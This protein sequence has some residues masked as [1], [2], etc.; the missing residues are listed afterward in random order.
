M[1]AHNNGP[2]SVQARYFLSRLHS[3]EKVNSSVLLVDLPDVPKT[4]NFYYSSDR[5]NDEPCQ[6]NHHLKHT[7]PHHCF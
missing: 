5:Y 3:L 4:T 2:L 6:D 7:C 1:L